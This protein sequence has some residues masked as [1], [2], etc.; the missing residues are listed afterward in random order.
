MVDAVASW[1]HT[2]EDPVGKAMCCQ[3]LP[4][5]VAAAIEATRP[6][7]ATGDRVDDV[8]AGQDLLARRQSA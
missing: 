6:Q 2:D 3:A 1:D 4:E 5:A 8:D 7:P